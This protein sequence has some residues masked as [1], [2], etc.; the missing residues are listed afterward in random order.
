MRDDI[1][2][3]APLQGAVLMDN[4]AVIDAFPRRAQTQESGIREGRHSYTRRDSPPI[5]RLCLSLVAAGAGGRAVNEDGETPLHWAAASSE[6][7]VAPV[8]RACPCRRGYKCTGEQRT[9]AA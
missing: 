3:T 8:I 4:M 1:D 7:T 6:R 5:W 9:D 2:Y